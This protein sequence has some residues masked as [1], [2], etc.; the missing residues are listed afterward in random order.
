M[1][2][3]SLVMLDNGKESQPPV[4]HVIMKEATCALKYT[5]S[6]SYDVLCFSDY[7]ISNLY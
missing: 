2:H 1:I 6:L 3:G 7:N 5:V 4:C